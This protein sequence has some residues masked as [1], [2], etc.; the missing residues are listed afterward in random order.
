MNG[1]GRQ[2]WKPKWNKPQNIKYTI[3]FYLQITNK[4]TYGQ[5]ITSFHRSYMF[6]RTRVIIR[7]LFYAC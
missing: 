1:K 6:R 4:L 5:F 7:E 2:Q 3:Y